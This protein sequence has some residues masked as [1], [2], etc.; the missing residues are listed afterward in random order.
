MRG[1]FGGMLLV[2]AIAGV[3]FIARDRMFSSGSAEAK[4]AVVDLCQGLACYQR[5]PA[6]IDEL[7][8]NNHLRA[9]DAAASMNRRKASFSHQAY[10]EAILP[11]M[12]QEARFYKEKETSEELM[13]LYY[14]GL[15]NP[16]KPRCA[17]TRPPI[18]HAPNRK[19]RIHRP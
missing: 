13:G 8:E 4:Q 6:F 7:I 11:A 12:A 3:V 18:P 10:V 1:S 16:H 19:L 2:L 9:F 5:N 15:R 17:S 14:P